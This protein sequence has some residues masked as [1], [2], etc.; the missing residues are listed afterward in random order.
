MRCRLVSGICIEN[1]IDIPRH[2]S[3]RTVSIY[4]YSV[5]P[6]SVRHRLG[7]AHVETSV[8]SPP[9]NSAETQHGHIVYETGI[10]I[11]ATLL[12]GA[13]RTL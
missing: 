3:R 5:A 8:P 2:I 9:T 7:E 11:P 13:V 10:D 6:S 1:E 4:P 12:F